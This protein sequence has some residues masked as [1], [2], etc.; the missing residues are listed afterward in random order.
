M[1]LRQERGIFQESSELQLQVL[2]AES[3]KDI[4][5]PLIR[6][7]RAAE[8]AKVYSHLQLVFQNQTAFGK[9]VYFQ[10]EPSK[11]R[12]LGCLPR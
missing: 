3:P 7:K 8:A 9:V 4:C 5:T 10:A 11:M 12:V 1:G 6:K 2:S